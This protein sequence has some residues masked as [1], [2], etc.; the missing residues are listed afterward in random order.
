MLPYTNLSLY[1]TINSKNYIFHLKKLI[2][3]A[4]TMVFGRKMSQGSSFK[5]DSQ[6]NPNPNFSIAMRC[7][8]CACSQA[9]LSHLLTLSYWIHWNY[10]V[11]LPLFSKIKLNSSFFHTRKKNNFQSFLFGGVCKSRLY[12]LDVS[13][14]IPVLDSMLVY[15]Y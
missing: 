10:D 4:A 15:V 1:W 3:S 6:F 9:F 5:K 7:C 11:K 13:T 8:A 2:K 12:S 14:D